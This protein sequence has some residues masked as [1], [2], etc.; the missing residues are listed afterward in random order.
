M[1]D[2]CLSVHTLAINCTKSRA[3]KSVK[4]LNTKS[5]PGRESIR[6][7]MKVALCWLQC[8]KFDWLV[9]VPLAAKIYLPFWHI[10]STCAAECV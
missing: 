8:K 3:S 4:N 7:C 6:G 9:V 10:C 5:E 1:E 2:R